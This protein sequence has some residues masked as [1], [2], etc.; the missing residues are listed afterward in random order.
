MKA[1]TRIRRITGALSLLLLLNALVLG[2]VTGRLELSSPDYDLFTPTDW[3]DATTFTLKQRI[4]AGITGY[5]YTS[6][7]TDVWLQGIVFKQ[8]S[9]DPRPVRLASFYVTSSGPIKVQQP[10]GSEFVYTLQLGALANGTDFGTAYDENKTEIDKLKDDIQGGIASLTG[11]FIVRVYLRDFYTDRIEDGGP[12]LDYYER[13]FDIP[14]ATPDQAKIQV[15]VDPVVTTPNPMIIV[16]L[17]PERPNLQYELAVYRVQD[18]ARDAVQNGIPMWR[19]VV[20]DGRTLLNYPVTATPL[21]SG[22]RYVI[23]GASFYQSSSSRQKLS[24]E[25]DLVEF[26][27]EDP[28]TST[29]SGAG[30]SSTPPGTPGQ[31]ATR[32]DPLL[33]IFGPNATQVPSA[34]AQSLTETLRQL[35]DRGWTFSEFRFN[36]RR[37][38]Q[39]ELVNLLGQFE[40]ATVTVVE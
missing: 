34:L 23:A 33:T 21:T 13:T 18:N 8:T 22:Q 4:P 39:S 14:F 17:P 11:K 12:Y 19:E 36:N 24:I 20:T 9:D 6:Q 40:N 29:S 38:T 25:A 26:R 30:G 27:Y 28:S 1:T 31:N 37:I 10:S 3:I 7:A 5:I 16:F 15:Q 2:Q 35:E 32:P